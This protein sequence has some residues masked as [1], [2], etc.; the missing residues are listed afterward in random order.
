VTGPRAQVVLVATAGL[1]VAAGAAAAGGL[2]ARDFVVLLGLS[3]GGAVGAGVIAAVALRALRSA[4]LSAQAA[5]AGLAPMVA[6]AVG[7]AGAASAMFISAHDLRVLLVVLPGAGTVAVITALVLGRRV[8]AGAHELARRAHRIGDDALPSEPTLSVTSTRELADVAA[9]LD[10]ALARL[11]ESRDRTAALERNRRELVAW[12]SHD[13]RTPLAGIRAM[14]EALEDGVVSDPETVA[15][16]HATM[17]RE[18]D[19]LA[20]LVDDLF[21]L[22]RLQAGAV[23]LGLESA[24]LG[25][26][27]SDAVAAAS[28]AAEAKGVRIDHRLDGGMPLVELSTPEMTRVLRNLLDNAIRHT[29]PGGLVLVEASVEHGGGSVAVAVSDT[30]GGIP[31][32]DL[33]RV[34]ELAY[35]GDAARAPADGGAGL[36]LAIARGLVDAH[37]GDI[38]V[39]NEGQGCTFTVRLPAGP[40]R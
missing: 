38:S 1:A 18:A 27:L 17:R 14:V 2:P 16:Y 15:R 32:A 24:P 33:P 37:E 20:C 35:R 26:L 39:R 34:F 40:H 31:D 6:V 5:A 3:G 30:C 23:S 19:R 11:A 25:E 13:L 12:V 9:Q 21:E 36:G 4:P 7:V 28:P 10:A 29:P 8:A 22:S